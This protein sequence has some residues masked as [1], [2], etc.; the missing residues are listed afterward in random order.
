MKQFVYPP[1]KIFGTR[2]GDWFDLAQTLYLWNSV[3]FDIATACA[4]RA[5]GR[6]NS[7]SD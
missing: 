6:A 4:V 2:E 3:P 7:R 1:E 5:G